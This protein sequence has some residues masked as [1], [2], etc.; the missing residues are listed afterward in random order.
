VDAIHKYVAELRAGGYASQ[1]GA[2]APPSTTS[3]STTTGEGHTALSKCVRVCLCVCVHDLCLGVGAW[4]ATTTV[5]D[6]QVDF[7][8]RVC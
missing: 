3:A 4:V 8:L 1:P 7:F 6:S 2:T 5:N